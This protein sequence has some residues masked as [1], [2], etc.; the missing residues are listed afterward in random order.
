MFN[1]KKPKEEIKIKTPCELYGHLYKDFPAYMEYGIERDENCY[2]LRVTE[3]YVC[4]VCGKRID[5]VLIS[6]QYTK[7]NGFNDIVEKHKEELADIL[8]PQAIVEDMI[9]D[10][11]LVDRERLKYW[12]QIHP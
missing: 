2:F 1:K 10:A 9:N 8:K 11:I 3:P 5:K 4:R 7:S 12:E 6:K